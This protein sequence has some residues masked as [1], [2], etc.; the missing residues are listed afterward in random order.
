VVTS[1][2]DGH[3]L[4]LE[5]SRLLR[6]YKAKGT[7]FIPSRHILKEQKLDKNDLNYL[8]PHFEIGTHTVSHPRLANLSF[9]EAEREINEGKDELD[10]SAAIP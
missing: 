7:F 9:E 8:A 2:D 6:R 5:L 1:W 4:D 3:F 10:K